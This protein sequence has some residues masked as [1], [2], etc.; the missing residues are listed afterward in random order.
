MGPNMFSEKEKKKKEKENK[1][2][3]YSFTIIFTPN[4]SV[5]LYI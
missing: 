4:Q 5:L 3:S 1:D 2:P